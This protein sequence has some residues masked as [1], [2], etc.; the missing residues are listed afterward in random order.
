MARLALHLVPC[1]AP[2]TKAADRG[3][4]GSAM[5][6]WW[7][8]TAGHPTGDTPAWLPA[9]SPH[10]ETTLATVADTG[11]AMAILTACL[12]A[13]DASPPAPAGSPARSLPSAR[14]F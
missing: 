12:A 11:P 9:T 6:T 2:A 8:D 7:S 13:T 5:S 1:A 14:C 10:S 3:D 4:G